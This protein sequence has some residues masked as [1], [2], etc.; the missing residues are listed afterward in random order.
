MF[1]GHV[2]VLSDT[3]LVSWMADVGIGTEATRQ[4]FP[5]LLRDEK[6]NYTDENNLP[7]TLGEI[8]GE[9]IEKELE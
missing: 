3:D 5:S 1:R 2:S 7:R 8:V 6:H 9:I 4:I